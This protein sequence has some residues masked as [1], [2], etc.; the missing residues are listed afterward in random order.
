[1][2]SG[3]WTYRAAAALALAAAFL[4]SWMNLAVGIAGDED[5]PVNLSFF[6]LIAVAVVGAFATEFRPKG[7]ARTLFSVAALQIMLGAI[8]ATGPV[9]SH[10]PSGPMGLAALNGFFALLWLVSAALF[11]KAAR[12]NQ[13]PGTRI[14]VT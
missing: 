5:N 6:M 11:A 1:M 8:V 2:A 12:P 3:T 13:G 4:I 14:D 9:A 7:L 10:E